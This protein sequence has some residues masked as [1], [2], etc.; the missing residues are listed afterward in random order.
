MRVAIHQ[1]H[2][3][4][5]LGYFDKM[6]KCDKFVLLDEVQFEKNSQMIRNRVLCDGNIKYITISAN[7]K[8]FLNKPYSEILIKDKDVWSKNQLNALRNYYRKSAYFEEI[9][10]MMEEFLNND[11]QTLCEWTV[12]SI[13][14][15][16]NMLEIH[17]DIILQSNIKRLFMLCILSI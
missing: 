7:T 14:L 8:G 9:Y 6:A 15:V 17:T 10:S 1:P 13:L 3:F 5:W 16:K 2:Y 4:P 12:N 11:Y